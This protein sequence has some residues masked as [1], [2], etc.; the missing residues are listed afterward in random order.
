[1]EEKNKIQAWKCEKFLQGPLNN[2][3]SSTSVYFVN[4]TSRLI[5]LMISFILPLN[6]YGCVYAWTTLRNGAALHLQNMPIL[7]KKIIFL[8]E[9][10]FGFGWYANK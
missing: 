2:F 4:G 5:W 1:M 6:E 8:D 9:T 3:F 7:A 10:H